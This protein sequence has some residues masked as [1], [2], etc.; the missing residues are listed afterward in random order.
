MPTVAKI[1]RYPVKGLSAELMDGVE[2]TPGL[3]LPH[4]RRFALA[5]GASRFDPAAP[6]WRPKTDFLMLMRNERLA[7]IESRFDPE[8]EFLTLFRGGKQVARAHTTDPTGH[9]I[10][11]Q[12]FDGLLGAETKGRVRLVESPGHMFSD[13]PNKVVSLIGLASI[14]DL[15]RVAGRPVDP[16]RF[17]A[18]FYVEGTRPW[19]EFGWAGREIVAGTARI[20]IIRPITRCAAT[21]VDPA[22]ATRDMNIP[23]LL[24]RGFGHVEMGVYGEVIGGGTVARGD[25][26]AVTG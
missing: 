24:Q 5:H 11:E 25:D 10:I 20:R 8:T 15:E 23:L 7:L 14:G 17:R 1:Y 13:N 4:D 21:D 9:A 26:I 6:E 22:T 2:L 16:V 3:A 19:E 12:F 18:N